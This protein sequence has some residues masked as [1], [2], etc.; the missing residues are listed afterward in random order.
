[1]KL[2]HPTIKKMCSILPYSP[3]EAQ[4]LKDDLN[5]D[6]DQLRNV[7]VYG[8]YYNKSIDEVKADIIKHNNK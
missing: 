4:Q 2:I 6:F 1:M 8:K 7:L 3:K 5:L